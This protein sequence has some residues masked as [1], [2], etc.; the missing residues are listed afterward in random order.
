MAGRDPSQD[1]W[2]YGPVLA[3]KPGALRNGAPFKDWLLPASL[4]RVR[5]KLAAAADGDRQMVDILTAVLSDGLPAVEAACTEALSHGAHSADVI[6]NILARRRERVAPIS[7]ATPQALRLILELDADKGHPV[8]RHRSHLHGDLGEAA[9]ALVVQL[10]KRV[11]L[12]RPAGMS[13][14][15]QPN[16]PPLNRFAAAVS[17]VDS[18]THENSP[19]WYAVLVAIS[20]LFAALIVPSLLA[21]AGTLQ[22]GV[23]LWAGLI[24]LSAGWFTRSIPITIIVGLGVYALLRWL[25]V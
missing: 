16:K 11:S 24:G 3:R 14:N 18:V 25:G 13:L 12:A 17:A 1:P 6:I 19:C 15:C 7:I 10:P 4:E 2:H 23:R 21:P 5:R 20:T 22:G 9:H 8:R